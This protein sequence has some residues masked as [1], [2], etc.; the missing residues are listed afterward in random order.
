MFAAGCPTKRAAFMTDMT[1]GR[2]SH[3]YL[4][5]SCRFI[6]CREWQPAKPRTGTTI[7]LSL[8]V[9]RNLILIHFEFARLPQSD[10]YFYNGS[11]SYLRSIWTSV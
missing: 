2:W 11:Y 10:I 3:V 8:H 6:I 9:C 4:Q 1:L 5:M 7:Q